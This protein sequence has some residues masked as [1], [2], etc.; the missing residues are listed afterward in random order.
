MSLLYK[1]LVSITAADLRAL[2]ENQV[3]ES[4]YIEYKQEVFDKRDE[5]KRLQFLGSISGFLN[6][7]GGDLLIGVKAEN[8]I[9]VELIGLEPA[10]ADSEMLRI[11]QVV[12]QGIEPFAQVAIQPVLL[13]NERTILIVRL[14]QS[15][16]APHGI[17]KD[18]HYQFYRRNSAGR[19]PMTIPELRTS[20][21]LASTIAEHTR[22]FQT[23]RLDAIR[24]PK[25]HGFSYSQKPLTVLHLVPF[26]SSFGA[27]TVE[28]TRLDKVQLQEMSSDEM[29][30]TA[31]GYYINSGVMRYNLDGILMRQ[32]GTGSLWH[33]QLFRD[34]SVEHV[35]ENFIESSSEGGTCYAFLWQVHL[36]KI[37]KRF[38][39]LQTTCGVIPPVTLAVS[40]L[41]T[42]NLRLMTQEGGG[43]R[44]L[45]DHR[46]DRREL[47]LPDVVINDFAE[48]PRIT[49]RPVFDSLWNAAGEQRCRFYSA[50][51]EWKVDPS[52]L[53]PVP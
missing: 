30:Q 14:A 8:G 39:K 52:W 5:K 15:W 25:R 26:S 10:T 22:R 4:L 45:S 23:Q 51:G 43:G 13:P 12:S 49:L 29:S 17:K 47:L 50:S 41:N 33:T 11:Q 2:V 20:F 31:R 18:E 27:S 36:M 35:F 40:L 16:A 32:I 53:D 44:S 34:G 24:M 7:L 9:P 28:I 42:T 6:A 21:S 38:L 3:P 1:P 48:D 46:I 37:L 19:S